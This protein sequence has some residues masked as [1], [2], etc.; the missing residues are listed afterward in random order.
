MAVKRRP[1]HLAFADGPPDSLVDGG[2]YRYIRHPFYTAY[3]VV[4]FAGVVATANGWLMAS[5]L[6]MTM[7]YAVAAMAAPQ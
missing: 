3:I 5:A 4:W 6:W 7:R 1:P 2:P